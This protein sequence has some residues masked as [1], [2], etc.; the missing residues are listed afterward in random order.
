MKRSPSS[1]SL[2]HTLTCS[3][4]WVYKAAWCQ[5]KV[6]SREGSLTGF[7]TD[8]ERRFR[9]R[10]TVIKRLGFARLHSNTTRVSVSCETKSLSLSLPFH[11]RDRALFAILAF[12]HD[13]GGQF[14]DGGRAASDARGGRA[15]P[16]LAGPR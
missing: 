3:T 2:S 12:L 10:P 13:H 1:R 6:L 5:T 11:F 4:S 7:L 8:S 9:T 16:Q 15:V 14:P